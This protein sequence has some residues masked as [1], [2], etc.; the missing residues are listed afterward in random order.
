MHQPREGRGRNRQ[1]PPKKK[2]KQTPQ[3]G[4]NPHPTTNARL[5]AKKRGVGQETATPPRS[6]APTPQRAGKPR[7]QTTP[8]ATPTGLPKRTT[9][10][11]PAEPVD[12]QLGAAAQRRKGH[13]GH[14][15]THPTGEVA[16]HPKKTKHRR[17]PN[18]RG[19]GDGDQ[20]AQ[21]RDR[22]RRTPESHDMTGPRTTPPPAARKKIKKRNGGGQIPPTATP[23]EPGPT[24]S[25]TRG[26]RETDGAHARGHRPQHANQKKRNAGE[27]QNQTHTHHEPQQGKADCSQNPYPGTHTLDPSQEWP[28]YRQTQPQMRAPRTPPGNGGAKPKPEPKHTHPR[29]RP[30]MAESPRNP[31]PNTNTTQQSETRCP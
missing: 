30:G 17:N 21:V 6:R 4:V 22:Q 2:K 7:G 16:G 12:T 28:G 19:R 26:M 24:G 25:P 9:E 29:P 31:D 27:T 11:H 20:E 23:A 15:G 18:G 1:S 10:D 14:A 8:K 13:P 3:K 5:P